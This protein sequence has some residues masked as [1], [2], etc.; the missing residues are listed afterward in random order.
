MPSSSRPP[1]IWSRVVA[2]LA[3][4]AGCRNWL[5]STRCPTRS[6]SVRLNSAVASVQA[7][8][9]EMS[10]TPGPYMW[11]YSHS[12][13]MPSSSQRCARCRTSAKVNPICG[14]YT[15]MSSALNGSLLDA[16]GVAQL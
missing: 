1:E 7:S 10:G 3:S 13:P 5:H 12:E 6:R 8:S 11:S 4:T 15:P 14:T 2:I 16:D 9:E